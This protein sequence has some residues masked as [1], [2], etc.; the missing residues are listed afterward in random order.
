[1]E[2]R[3]PIVAAP[4]AGGPSSNELA[5]AVA[6]TGALGFLGGGNKTAARLAKDYRSVAASGDVGVNL[7]V[8]DAANCAVDVAKSQQ[9]RAEK[10]AAFRNEL[11]P[12][13][14]RLGV[15]IP[16]VEQAGADVSDDWEAKLEAAVEWPIVSFTFGLPGP[17]VF[18][19]LHKSNT[20][21]GVTVTSAAEARNAADHGADFLVVQGPEA[22]GHRSVHDPLGTPETLELPK[23]LVAVNA[24]VD[25][26]LVAAG[27]I[28]T[29]DDVRKV[30]EHGAAAAAVGTALLLTDEAGS[31]ALHR[32]MLRTDR[33]GI[34]Q[35][36]RVHSGRVS[37]SLVNELMSLDAPAAYPEV[38]ALTVPIKRAAI[39]A[40]DPRS[41][42]LFAGTGYL[43][44]R[45]GSA[46][47]I[48][49]WLVG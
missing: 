32:Y 40:R 42:H 15:E 35:L 17:E 8:P 22:G 6:S 29:P 20:Q 41:T 5:R 3:H 38:N 27:G 7:F 12:F 18:Q 37:R 16:T 23:L 44:A 13:A 39:E 21:V 28:M 11:L 43:Q 48:I 26:P 31:N 24:V 9:G 14:Q 19:Q 10:L 36:T 46:V 45:T 47:E 30:Q 25:I 34:T 49:E 2:F 1:M 4:M 33:S